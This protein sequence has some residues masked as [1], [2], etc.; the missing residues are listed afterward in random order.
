VALTPASLTYLTHFSSFYVVGGRA[1][2]IFG[3]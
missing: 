3:P 2:G 1:S